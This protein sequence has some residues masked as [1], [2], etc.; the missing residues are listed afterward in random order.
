MKHLAARISQSC[1]GG[2]RRLGERAHL[3]RKPR[4]RDLGHSGWEVGPGQQEWREGEVLRGVS[5]LGTP[6]AGGRVEGSW[7]RRRVGPRWCRIWQPER[8]STESCLTASGRGEWWIWI[9]TWQ[10]DWEFGDTA[11]EN[12]QHT[13]ARFPLDRRAT[14]QL[15]YS[16]KDSLK[17]S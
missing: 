4:E 9:W 15:S 2:A 14:L 3:G 16:F 12:F 7:W 13:D 8:Q 17:L 1:P 11:N 6:W 5:N 10:E